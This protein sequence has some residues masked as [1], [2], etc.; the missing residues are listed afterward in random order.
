MT[1]IKDQFLN[2]LKRL[3]Y[4]KSKL[5]LLGLNNLCRPRASFYEDKV[6]LLTGFTL[7]HYFDFCA[8]QGGF[9]K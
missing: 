1:Y 5:L 3:S 2:S 4:G 9:N 8:P 6:T 7:M